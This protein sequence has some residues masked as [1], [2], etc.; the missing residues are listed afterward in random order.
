MTGRIM[1]F[2][3]GMIE[4]VSHELFQQFVAC[5]TQRLEGAPEAAGAA[6]AADQPIRLLPLAL[7]AIWAAIV[8]FFRRLFRSSAT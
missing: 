6:A 5:A 4:G 8:R 7:K 1:Q 2:G 3:Q